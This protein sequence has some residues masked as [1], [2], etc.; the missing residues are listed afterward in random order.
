MSDHRRHASIR[1]RVTTIAT[2]LVVVVLAVTLMS[3]AWF[4]RRSLTENLHDAIEQRADDLTDLLA[5]GATDV[6]IASGGEDTVAQVVDGG[7]VVVAAAPIEGLGPI[8]PAPEVTGDT[9][10]AVGPLRPGGDPYLVLSRNVTTPR[11]VVTL[12]VAGSRGDIDEA[13]RVLIKAIFWLVPLIAVVLAAATWLLVGK[14]L[15]P[16]E[17][18]RAE[19]DGIGGGDLHRRVP[20]PPG[21]D[22]IA[23][24]ASTMNDMLERIQIAYAAQDRFVADASHELRTPLTR[25]RAEL[26]LSLADPTQADAATGHRSLLEETTRMQHLVDDLLLLAQTN[27]GSEPDQQQLI[28]LDDIIFSEAQRLR[29]TGRHSIDVSKVAAAQVLGNPHRLARAIGNLTDNAERHAA[30]TVAF[31]LREHEGRAILAITDD[32]QGVPDDARDS[33]FERFG[34]SDQARSS[35]NGGAGLGL[36]IARDII[37]RVGG[38]LELDPDHQPGARFVA[39]FP[40]P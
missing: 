37:E 26:E 39:T 11:G 19:V 32:G 23:R 35:L 16:V 27:A 1:L 17:A 40:L 9:W 13:T 38:T 8:A 36:P 2:A 14:T 5:G 7:Q 20:Q 18:I 22:E 12:H 25:M 3:V 6:L 10:G 21:S 34:R 33:I 24:L 30:T 4:Q 29:A 31:S 28:D 15:S